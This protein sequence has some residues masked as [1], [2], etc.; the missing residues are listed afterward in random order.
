MRL[1]PTRLSRLGAATSRTM[2]SS[3]HRVG[4]PPRGGTQGQPSGSAASRPYGEAAPL[5]TREQDSV[6]F[7]YADCAAGCAGIA[8]TA[9][10][11]PDCDV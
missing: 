1:P 5:R 8:R 4:C 9:M 7:A 2:R 6:W 10:P 3:G 11:C